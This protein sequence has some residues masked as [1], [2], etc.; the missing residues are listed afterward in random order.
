V[1]RLD[2][3]T[4]GAVVVAKGPVVHAKLQRAMAVADKVYLAV[5][6]GRVNVARERIDLKLGRDPSDRRRVVASATIG[7]DSV[8]EVKR[9][10]RGPE[11]SLLQCRL[12]TGRMHQ[13]RAHLFARG[14]PIVGDQKYGRPQRQGHDHF[15]FPRQA[16]HAWRTA[17]AHPMTGEPVVVEAPLPE[18]LEHLLARILGPC[19]SDVL[20]PLPSRST[21]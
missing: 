18:D 3:Q 15:G 4:S 10:A 8:T 20:P 1:G 11:A 6:Y 7:A 9:L 2:K 14:W 12:V 21:S 17:F 19:W 5:V 16:L 13:I